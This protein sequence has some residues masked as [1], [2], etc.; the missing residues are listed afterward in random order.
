MIRIT[1]ASSFQIAPEKSCDYLDNISRTTDRV[2]ICISVAILDGRKWE[3]LGRRGGGGLFPHHF[4][5]VARPR[6]I[7]CSSNMASD[8]C[9][10]ATS[11]ACEQANHMSKFCVMQCLHLIGY[12]RVTLLID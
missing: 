9:F 5:L 1:S 12:L 4:V 7:P 11:I 10:T 6:P 8:T 3:H 2:E